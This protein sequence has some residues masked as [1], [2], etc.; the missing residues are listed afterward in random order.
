MF[1]RSNFA[2]AACVG[3]ANSLPKESK[4]RTAAS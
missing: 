1:S 2:A 3:A 4:Y